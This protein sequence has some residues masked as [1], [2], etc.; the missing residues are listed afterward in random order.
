MKKPALHGDRSP[1]REQVRKPRDPGS[2]SLAP[3]DPAEQGVA[4]GGDA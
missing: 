4:E 2:A 1:Y 3:V